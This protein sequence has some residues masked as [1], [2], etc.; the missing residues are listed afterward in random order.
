MVVPPL[1]GL[2]SFV[3]YFLHEALSSA[4]FSFR[5][6]GR[7]EG[8]VSVQLQSLL[9]FFLF[10]VFQECTERM[11]RKLGLNASRWRTQNGRELW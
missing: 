1:T 4:S 9:N 7:E 6:C 3:P 5:V 2:P 8:D 10:R 11:M